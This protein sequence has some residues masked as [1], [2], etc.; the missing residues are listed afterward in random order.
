MNLDFFSLNVIQR[1]PI[2]FGCICL[3]IQGSPGDN[4]NRHND[5]NTDNGITAE[6][7]HSIPGLENV[8]PADIISSQTI[9]SKTR[10]VETITVSFIY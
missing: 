3:Y 2:L 8:D 6:E 7:L 4:N 10:T 9:S 5:N 1:I